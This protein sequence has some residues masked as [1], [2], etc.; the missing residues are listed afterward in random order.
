MTGKTNASRRAKAARGTGPVRRR[1]AALA[2]HYDRRWS[3]YVAA[4]VGATLDEVEIAPGD[5]VLD[6]GCGT[7]VLLESLA[8]AGTPA[9]TGTPVRLYG[10]DA[11]TQMLAVARRRLAGLAPLTGG[12]AE[13]L[14]FADGSFDW[15]ISTNVF[16]Y[17]RDPD[18]VL[19]EMRRVLKKDGRL[20][21]T[22]WCDDFLA[23]RVCDLLLRLVDRSHHRT[24]GAREF[25]RMLTRA[26]LPPGEVRVFKINWLWG[27]MTAR[28]VN[29]GENPVP[30]AANLAPEKK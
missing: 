21:I 25:N 4:T 26:G 16:H 22:D 20:V 28:A 2:P 29:G 27:L 14:P 5:A 19:A 6:I 7:G 9:R 8:R 1:Y 13:A 12:A 11:S 15:L 3:S 10:I 18:R 23:C 24:Y 30:G 17:F